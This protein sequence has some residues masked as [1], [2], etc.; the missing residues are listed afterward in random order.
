MH[1]SW[2][3]GLVALGA[4]LAAGCMPAQLPPVALLEIDGFSARDVVTHVHEERVV[5]CDEGHEVR[6]TYVAGVADGAEFLLT[7]PSTRD[8]APGADIWDEHERLVLFAHGYIPPSEPSGFPDP[9]P[10]SIVAL[11]DALTCQGFALAASSYAANG[12]AVREGVRDTHLLNALFARHFG[13]APDR[14]FVVGQSMGGLV[15]LRLVEHYPH[16]YDG[17]LVFCAPS[18]GSL[19]QLTY[20]GHV[21]VLAAHF[22]P[23]LFAAD[24]LTPTPR[25]LAE[26][27]RLVEAIDEDALLAL[28]SM[29]LPG[30]QLF[31]PGGV[32]L[33][34]TD[35]AADDVVAALRASLLS[36]LE[37]WEVGMADV[38]ERGAGSPFGNSTT[39]YRSDALGFAETLAL[40]RDVE[41]HRLSAAALL[42]WLRWYQPRGNLRLPVVSMH[43]SADASVPIAHAVVYAELAKIAG[44]A[45]LV[46]V[47]PIERYGHCTFT[48]EELAAGLAYVVTWAETGARPP[49]AAASVAAN[50][51]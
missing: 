45:D 37:Y 43:T 28:G 35:P 4:C 12:F 25:S 7:K 50:R 1:R 15:T 29:R 31:Q 39:Y 14:T 6:Y 24:A 48:P 27:A 34:P 41:R 8:V 36:A 22:F 18:G 32:P 47:Y 23:E 13:V 26:V 2:T 21:R 11:R 46:L 5:E 3:S 16:R 40:N 51:P 44:A 10:S 19:L 9:L 42:H 30:S 33:L 20:V 17:A 49:L 38:L